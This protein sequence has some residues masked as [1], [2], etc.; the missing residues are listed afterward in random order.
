LSPSRTYA[1]PSGIIVNTSG[2]ISAHRPSPVHKSWSIQTLTIGSIPSLRYNGNMPQYNYRCSNGHTHE[3]FRSILEDR[4]I[5]VCPEC[6][7]TLKQIYSPPMI[8]LKG[9]GFYRNSKK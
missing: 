1:K 4:K 9:S 7:A 2:A 5:D 8:E 3:E 6:N